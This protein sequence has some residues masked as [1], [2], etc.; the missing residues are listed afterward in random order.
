[1]AEVVRTAAPKLTPII[2]NRVIHKEER[3]ILATG[4][5]VELHSFQRVF[6]FSWLDDSV[7]VLIAKAKL[8]LISVSAAIGAIRLR[9]EYRVSTARTQ[10]L[11]GIT[12]KRSRRDAHRRMLTFERGLTVR[13]RC[14]AQSTIE[15]LTPRVDRAVIGK[16]Q[17]VR[18]TTGNFLNVAE[19]ID[20]SW[21]VARA[22]LWVPNAQPT[23]LIASHGVDVAPIALHED[24][25]LLATANI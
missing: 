24:S 14:Q 12:S 6:N 23:L 25:V 8:T 17:S 20:K 15:S 3:V 18:R 9:H 22:H 7:T 16:G 21:D 4:D 10:I 19:A 5:R 13:T 1:M 2:F 11:H